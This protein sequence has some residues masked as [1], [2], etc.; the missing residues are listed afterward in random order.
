MRYSYPVVVEQDGDGWVITCPDV[1][2][3]TTGGATRGEAFAR[4]PY[5]LLAALTLYL[6]ER[7]A[8]PVPSAAMGRPMVAVPALEVE[9]LSAAKR[10]DG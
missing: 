5:A 8:L 4:A 6:D 3:M 1:P 2:G 7:K 9:R 10:R